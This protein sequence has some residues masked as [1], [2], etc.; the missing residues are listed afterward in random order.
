MLG[1]GMR[2]EGTVKMEKNRK[3]KKGKKN[4]GRGNNRMALK[5]KGNEKYSN[6]IFPTPFWTK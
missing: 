3:R 4:V 5:R 2:V 1:N 6:F